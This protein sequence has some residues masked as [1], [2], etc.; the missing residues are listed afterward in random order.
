MEQEAVSVPLEWG[1]DA[2]RRLARGVA[3]PQA[4]VCDDRISSKDNVRKPF[5]ANQG[6]LLDASRRDRLP[7]GEAAKRILE[8]L[9]NHLQFLLYEE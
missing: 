8:K 5:A 2:A 3:A 6:M 7:D 9:N 1:A 4:A